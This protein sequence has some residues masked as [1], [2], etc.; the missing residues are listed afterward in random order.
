MFL[1]YLLDRY[2]NVLIIN[3]VSSRIQPCCAR[4]CKLQYL[5]I[6]TLYYICYYAIMLCFVTFLKKL[7]K[8]QSGW[9]SAPDPDGGTY[10]APTYPLAECVRIPCGTPPPSQIL[11]TPLLCVCVCVCVFVC[12]CVCVSVM[13]II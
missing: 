1:R 11:H 3:L 10:S 8:L 9:G 12:M 7:R 4:V 2:R 5:Y 6:Y 13:L